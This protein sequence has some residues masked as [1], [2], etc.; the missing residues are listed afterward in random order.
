MDLNHRIENVP[1][2]PGTHKSKKSVFIFSG[3]MKTHFK[4]PRKV[5][6]LCVY[7]LLDRTEDLNYRGP[8]ITFISNSVKLSR[9]FKKCS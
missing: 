7:T 3:K 6:D 8:V 9:I 2:R 5:F 1:Q 4:N